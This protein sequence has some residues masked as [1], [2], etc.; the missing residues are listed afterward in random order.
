MIVGKKFKKKGVSYMALPGLKFKL[1]IG[2]IVLANPGSIENIV[3]EYFNVPIKKMIGIS[4][5]AE[6]L[7]PRYVAM[8]LLKNH[9]KL[10]LKE[11]GKR[12]NGRD[13]STVI[14]SL[15]NV[16]D[17]C[18]SSQWHRMAFNDVDNLIEKMF[19]NNH[20]K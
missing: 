12:F 20:L 13:H 18:D 5:K 2:R 16:V 8:A 9:T 14:K 10:S 19:K 1:D 15:K 3:A 17:F 6:Y 11:I 4:R 7:Y